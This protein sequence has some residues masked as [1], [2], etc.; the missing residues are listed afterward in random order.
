MGKKNS[1]PQA[2]SKCLA[3]KF[4]CRNL[5][6]LVCLAGLVGLSTI[7]SH[8]VYG[9]IDFYLLDGRPWWPGWKALVMHSQTNGKTPI[10]TDY[11]TGYYVLYS[12][13]GETPLADM[14]R[15]KGG[16]LYVEDM[17][18]FKKDFRC[19]INLI[20]YTSS[21]IPE[22]TRHWASKIGKTSEFYK[23]KARK[24]EP[25][26]NFTLKNFPLQ[27]CVVFAPENYTE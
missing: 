4:L 16:T 10:Y 15:H 26:I 11:V 5:F 23:L 7:R 2:R 14:F 27:K 21:W 19:V 6:W 3:K 17:E 18:N 20:G 9:K 22:E 13:F 25:D 12:V 1:P 24:G 8:P